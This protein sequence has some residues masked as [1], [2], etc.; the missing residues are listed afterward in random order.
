MDR[1]KK[2]FQFIPI[3]A[4]GSIGTSRCGKARSRGN[5]VLNVVP[6]ARLLPGYVLFIGAYMFLNDL[7]QNRIGGSGTEFISDMRWW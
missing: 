4:F 1:F 7:R 3:G 6:A 5:P 2:L